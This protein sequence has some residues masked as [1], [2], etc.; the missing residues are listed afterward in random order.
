M[1]NDNR[2]GSTVGTACTEK[3]YRSYATFTVLFTA[4]LLVRYAQRTRNLSKFFGSPLIQHSRSTH[5][6]IQRC[7]FGLR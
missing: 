1:L 6:L 7:Y 5:G 3:L 4:T 2:I